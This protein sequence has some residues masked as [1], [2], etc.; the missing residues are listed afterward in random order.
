MNQLRLKLALINSDARVDE[1]VEELTKKLKAAAIVGTLVVS[2]YTVGVTVGIMRESSKKNTNGVI[3]VAC[4]SLTLA[5]LTTSYYFVMH[6][7]R[8]E[9]AKFD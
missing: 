9:M 7:L 6:K 8:Q 5:V 4:K 2:L 3:I 1:K